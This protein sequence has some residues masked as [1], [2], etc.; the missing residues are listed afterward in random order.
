MPKPDYLARCC[1]LYAG[2]IGLWF[3]LWLVYKDGLWW[4]TL[5]NRVIP[6]LFF[7][8]THTHH[9]SPDFPPAT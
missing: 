2:L 5:L 9:G 8:F 1:L 3:L 6:Y 7:A 4:L